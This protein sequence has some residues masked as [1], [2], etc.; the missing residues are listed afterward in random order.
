M[1]SAERLATKAVLGG[2]LAIL[3]LGCSANKCGSIPRNPVVRLIHLSGGDGP[4]V[5]SL[6]VYENGTLEM[7]HLGRRSHCA[8]S[9]SN[10]VAR[11]QAIMQS[12]A[13]STAVSTISADRDRSA[14]SDYEQVIVQFQGSEFRIAVEL[15][16]PGLLPFFRELDGAFKRSFGS[17]YRLSLAPKGRMAVVTTTEKC[18]R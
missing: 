4:S 13:F 18:I 1:L 10:F 3:V 2:V 6:A 15:E 12:A 16:P 11:L 14:P 5:T 7:Q 8:R 9:D 17:R